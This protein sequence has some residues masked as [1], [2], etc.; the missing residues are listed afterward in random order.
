MVA[1]KVRFTNPC[2]LCDYFSNEP[3][4]NNFLSPYVGIRDIGIAFAVMPR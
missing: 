4:L 3:V 1:F 2:K